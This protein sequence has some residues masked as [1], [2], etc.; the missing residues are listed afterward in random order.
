MHPEHIKEIFDFYDN[1]YTGCLHFIEKGKKIHLG[2]KNNKSCRFCSKSH[3]DVT[4][5]KIAHALP[6]MIGNKS[7]FS[8]YEC[9]SCNEIFANTIEDNLSKYLG[10]GRTLF[11]LRGKN[12]VPKYK[13]NKKDIR[14][15]FKDDLIIEM[16]SL[17][18]DISINDDS[19]KLSISTSKQKYI[20]LFVYK[21]LVKMVLSIIDD[22]ELVN[23]KK[24]LEWLE[25]GNTR[26]IKI[27]S[28]QGVVSVCP[29]YISNDNIYA[30]VF[31]RKNDTDLVPYMSFFIVFSCYSFQIFIPFSPKDNHIINKDIELK[32]LPPI[33]TK[34]S[35]THCFSENFASDDLIESKLNKYT[36]N[37]ESISS[38]A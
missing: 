2:D 5:K 35:G 32:T 1:H 18:S 36:M 33:M 17:Y 28:L 15:H 14:I 24:T 25:P 23:F 27:K 13:S 8:N 11:K 37:Y 9:D 16:D 7:L 38:K 26:N 31:K 19:K 34:I 4:F 20:P 12:G 10:A 21:C 30:Y 3:P 29:S 6:E 22:S